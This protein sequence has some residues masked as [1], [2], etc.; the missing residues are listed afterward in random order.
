M[1]QRSGN[2]KI[3]NIRDLG[4]VLIHR[5][6]IIILVMA[7]SVG[8]LFGVNKMFFVPEYSSTATLYILRQGNDSSTTDTNNDFSL[9]L[10]VV[11]D[12]NYLLKS[13]M[14]LDKVIK[15]LSLDMSYDELYK[16]V[17]TSNPEDS[18]V[19]EVTVTA[20]SPKEAKRIADE[21]CTIGADSIENAMGFRQVNLYEYGTKETTPSN[22]L[23]LRTYAIVGLIGGIIAYLIFLVIY[24]FDDRLRTNEEIERALGV[25]ILGEI[26]NANGTHKGKYGYY[27]KYYQASSSPGR[28]KRSKHGRRK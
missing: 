16:R 10:S 28:T 12:C 1:T 2:I 14:V 7:L 27:G 8:V 20:G 13:H 19:L 18:R 24:M 11:N 9:A 15:N 23:S 17:S 22:L 3:L 25:T 21:V 6:P 5:L 26:P 4:R